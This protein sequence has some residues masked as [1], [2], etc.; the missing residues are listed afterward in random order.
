M[1][2]I[3][4]HNEDFTLLGAM[5]AIFVGF[6]LFSYGISM[7]NAGGSVKNIVQSE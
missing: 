5:F 4:F 7:L 6:S 2:T 3:H 1:A